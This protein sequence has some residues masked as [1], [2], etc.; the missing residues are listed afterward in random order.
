MKDLNV[1]IDKDKHPFEA[2]SCHIMRTNGDY[3]IYL[4]KVERIKKKVFSVAWWIPSITLREKY[5]KYQ[6]LT[7]HLSSSISTR[8]MSS[9][10]WQIQSQGMTYSLSR[11]NRQQNR[12]GPG[13]I[14]A[15]RQLV[16]QL[17]SISMG[18]PR[19]RQVQ[20][21]MTS[22]CLNSQMRMETHS[23]KRYFC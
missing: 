22:F 8:I 23:F 21:L 11:P 10:I 3:N 20:V 5:K 15:V 7:K 14:R 16:L 6:P 18:Q 9:P 13:R 19:L 12:P 4:D 1:E 17:N 2:Y